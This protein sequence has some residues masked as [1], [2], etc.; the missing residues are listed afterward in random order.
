V[1][2]ALAWL[3]EQGA[4]VQPNG[5]GF[6]L[7]ATKAGMQRLIREHVGPDSISPY[8][9]LAQDRI[10]GLLPKEV[11]EQGLA[12]MYGLTRMQLA[13]I[14]HR[15]AQEGWIRR[16]SG[17]GWQFTEIIDSPQSHADAYM[18][19]MAVEPA[20]ILAPTYE[21]DPLAIARLR[22]EQIGLRD[23]RLGKITSVDLFE[24][25]ARFHQTIIGFSNNG[26]F[27]SSLERI[28][29]LRRLV[30]YRA[31]AQ[32]GFYRQQNVEHIELLDLLEQGKRRAAA[33]F[34]RRHL[35]VV[36]RHKMETLSKD[37]LLE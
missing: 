27:V 13:P 33:T 30:E 7:S 6:E 10:A 29:Q 5:R 3:V 24:I 26:Y 35:N 4:A 15:M 17:H 8:M 14:L 34:L 19:R 2:Q 37:L 9:K 22:A 16:K 20:A 21:V 31:M 25:G 23:G 11:T 18:F 12:K 36:L 32:P 1:Q 28:N